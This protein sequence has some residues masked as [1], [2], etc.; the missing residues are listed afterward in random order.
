MRNPSQDKQIL[1]IILIFGIAVMIFLIAL[2]I[3]EIYFEESGLSALLKGIISFLAAVIPSALLFFREY[4]KNDRENQPVVSL[5]ENDASKVGRD[6]FDVFLFGHSGTGKTSFIQRLFTFDTSPLRSTKHFDYYEIMVPVNL[7]GLNNKANTIKVRIADYKGQD[8]TQLFEAARDNMYID[9]ILFFA[10]VAP[11]YDEAGHKLEKEEIVELM[12]KDFEGVL[13]KRVDTHTNK[14]LSEFLLQAV[15][16]YASSDYLKSVRLVI[17][18]YDILE[19]LQK[20]GVI[21]PSVDLDQYTRG[22]FEEVD[23]NLR[24]FCHENEILDYSTELVSIIE[25]KRIRALFTGLLKA[26]AN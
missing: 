9:A 12:A 16:T 23:H 3:I 2:I 25:S 26:S 21:E 5:V 1:R 22:L 6:T 18:K 14:Y 15:F 17:N 13:Q 7:Q 10:D 19:S 20:A 4:A 11:A 8:V 24:R